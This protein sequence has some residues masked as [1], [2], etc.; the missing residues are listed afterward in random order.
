MEAVVTAAAAR[1]RCDALPR[2]LAFVPTMGALH[3]GHFALL[4]RARA[5]SSSLAASVFVNPLQFG[6]NEDLERYP[7]DLDRDAAALRSEGVD[8]LF[9]P[10]RQTMYGPHFSTA[11]DV[12]ELARVYEGALRPGHFPG[13][14][15]VVLKLLNIVRP[16]AIY[17][18]Q[19][20][21]QQTAVIRRMIADL[22]VAIRVEIVPTVRDADG[23][24]LSSRNAYLTAAER[25]QA[26]S[27]HRT[28][29][30][31]A[32]AM[33]TGLTKERAIA[34]ARELL[35]K[36]AVLEYLDVVD[37]ETF[38]P[39]DRLRPPAFVIAAARF[40]ATRLLDNVWIAE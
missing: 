18:G 26:P 11:V 9:A 8:V 6:P 39:L 12:G 29:S 14:A 32:E 28:V 36:D 2:P 15:T 1:A 20:D 37:A 7:R 40:G 21:A 10:E 27:L 33:R 25:E 16:D 5:E 4:R 17:L 3:D 24:A 31:A 35:A 38:E 13:V 19:K 22:D 34:G 30:A 23:L